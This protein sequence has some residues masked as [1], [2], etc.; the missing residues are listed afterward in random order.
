MIS[1]LRKSLLA[2]SI[3]IV[4]LGVATA[5]Y[6]SDSLVNSTLVSDS[7]VS[8]SLSNQARDIAILLMGNW[9]N[10][11][12]VASRDDQNGGV[13][14]HETV[15]PFAFGTNRGPFHKDFPGLVAGR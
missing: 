1:I 3:S 14:A 2:V 4:A 12:I 13:K 9:K 7:S 5:T 8:E 11:L 6:L 15:S 10:T